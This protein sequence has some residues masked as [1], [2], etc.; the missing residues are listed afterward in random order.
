[1]DSRNLRSTVS[2]PQTSPNELALGISDS[3]LTPGSKGYVKKIA[4]K[5][6]K[7]LSGQIFSRQKKSLAAHQQ[8]KPASASAHQQSKPA[9]A[10]TQ[11]TFDFTKHS[12]ADQTDHTKEQAPTPLSERMRFQSDEI[13]NRNSISTY[14]IPTIVTMRDDQKQLVKKRVKDPCKEGNSSSAGK[15][16]EKVL[17]VM[18]ATGAGKS[19]LINGMINYI[20][21]VKWEDNFR[22]KLIND[23]T[24]S[25]QAKSVTKEI[26][27][28][29]VHPIEGSA[30]P[31]KFTI[32]DTPGYGDTEGLSR[33]QFITNQ[34]KEFFSL[35]PPLGIDHLDAIGF[36][37]QSALARLTA[38]QKYIFDAILSIFGKDMGN[39]IFMMVTFSDGE[40]P[41]VLKAIEE[42]KISYQKS[43]KFNNSALFASTSSRFNAMFWEMGIASF[44]EFFGQ[45]QSTKS[46][47]LDQTKSVL[48][49]REE[50]EVLVEGLNPQIKEGL[51]KLD[52]MRL[53]KSV[54]QEHEAAMEHNKDFVYEVPVVKAKQTDLRGTGK[55]TTTCLACNF[56]CHKDCKIADDSEKRRCCAMDDNGNC[57]VCTGRCYWE[58]HKNQPFLIEY[59]TV[60]EKRTSEDLKKKY[61]MAASGKSKVKGMLQQL[62][63]IYNDLRI[64]VVTRMYKVRECLQRLDEIAL[65]PNPL[66]EV[67]YIELL[68]STEQREHQPGFQGRINALEEVKSKAQM[69]AKIKGAEEIPQLLDEI[70]PQ[71][72]TSN[73]SGQTTAKSSSQC[74]IQ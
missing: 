45:F 23:P 14:K 15:Q 21:G 11:E 2:G 41:P 58:R 28:Y 70:L 27:A 63:K 38:T 48:N 62:E 22:F 13:E 12:Q 29:T 55:H 57:K 30:L 67:E 72:Q 32:I 5:I 19:T 7:L 51:A 74:T 4:A 31:Y 52:E 46:V 71:E 54:L 56:T 73:A 10:S 64:E 16:N 1:M 35:E 18:G 69:F 68:I 40:D 59:E 9:S 25:S 6:E 47:K 53:E 65:K 33:D 17:L 8:S 36:V 39:N 37:T 42:A 20:L 60:Y 61:E 24:G 26:T 49:E 3:Q 34:I 66:T 43:F 44:E 50:L